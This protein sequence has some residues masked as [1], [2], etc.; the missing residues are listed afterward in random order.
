MRTWAQLSGEQQGRLGGL[1][2]TPDEPEPAPV[3]TRA[4]KGTGGLAAPFRLG[5]AALVQYLQRKGH[6]RPVLR[7]HEEPVEV[8]CQ[9][10]VAELGVFI[11][12]TKTRRHRLT[13]EQRQALTKLGIEWT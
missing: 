6:E 4:A 11:S 10:H 1:G 3:T 9:E 7:K 8:D 5:V 13:P 2:L 12:N